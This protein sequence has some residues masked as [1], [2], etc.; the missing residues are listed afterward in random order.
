MLIYPGKS[1]YV[2]KLTNFAGSLT[3]T[4]L[5]YLEYFVYDTVMTSS[6]EQVIHNAGRL[7]DLST[8]AR[9]HPIQPTGQFMVY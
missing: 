9:S 1:S 5:E 2:A 3:V 4:C 6:G 8:N 7:R